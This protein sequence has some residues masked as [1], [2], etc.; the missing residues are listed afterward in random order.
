MAAAFGSHPA[1][2]GRNRKD[3]LS[4]LEG[5]LEAGSIAVCVKDTRKRVLTQNRRC[6]RVCGNRLGKVCEVGC[7]ALYSR[8]RRQQWKGWGSRVYQNSSVHGTFYDVTLLC[9]TD[10]IITFLQPLKERY[11]TALTYY[12]EKGLTRREMEVMALAIRGI[13]NTDICERLA[14]S[15]ATLRT[16]LNNVYTK[17]REAGDAPEFIP[18]NRIAS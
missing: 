12:R 4:V 8:D 10:R 18:P 7:M 11:E 17:L 3:D 2:S 1:R 15:K 13:S 5:S 9:T 6:R 16:H 14:I